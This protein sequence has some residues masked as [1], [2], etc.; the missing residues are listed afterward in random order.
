MKIHGVTGN[1]AIDGILTAE[2]LEELNQ[3]QLNDVSAVN[4]YW[5][6]HGYGLPYPLVIKPTGYGKGRVIDALLHPGQQSG[7]ALLIVGTKNILVEQ[8]QEA[9]RSLVFEETG[10]TRFSILPDTSGPVIVATWQ[11][12][13]AYRKKFLTPPEIDLVIVDE[14]HNAGTKNA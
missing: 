2:E 4:G 5:Q 7:T 6:E 1:L 13:D 10:E 14:V 9:L 12:I 11:S 8:N 3:S